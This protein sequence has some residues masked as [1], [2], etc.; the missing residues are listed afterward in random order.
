MAPGDLA[1]AVV[2][3]GQDRVGLHALAD[4]AQLEVVPEIADEPAEAAAA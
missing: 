2:S 1:A 4:D 3:P